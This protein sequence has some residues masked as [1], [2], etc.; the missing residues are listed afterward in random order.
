M[1]QGYSFGCLLT[2]GQAT[3]LYSR[4]QGEATREAISQT[5]WSPWKSR[6][7]CWQESPTGGGPG[8]NQRKGGSRS[9]ERKIEKTGKKGGEEKKEAALFLHWCV[10]MLETTTPQNNQ[11]LEEEIQP[12]LS[13]GFVVIPSVYGASGV[14]PRRLVS[15]TPQEPCVEKEFINRPCHWLPMNET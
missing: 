5:H 3:I 10:D 13:W 1:L 12:P 15:Q 6:A 11:T 2:S 7:R 9:R 14:P 8:E 4:E